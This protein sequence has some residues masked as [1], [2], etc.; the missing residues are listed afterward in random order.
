MESQFV[1][2]PAFLEAARNAIAV[3]EPYMV[4]AVTVSLLEEVPDPDNPAGWPAVSSHFDALVSDAT[5][6]IIWDAVSE[7]WFIIFG[8][9]EGGWQFLAETITDPVTIV[10]YKI[11][12]AGPNY[13]GSIELAPVTVTVT[14]QAITL[15]YVAVA[16][17]DLISAAVAP[18]TLT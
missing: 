4:D 6:T 2:T 7:R 17:D 18:L 14:G 3:M 8:D 15:P 1:P 12:M 16:L 13:V 11:T 10:G 5:P 9:P